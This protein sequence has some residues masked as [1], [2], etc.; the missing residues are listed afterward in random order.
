MK[1]LI[2]FSTLITICLSKDEKLNK[3]ECIDRSNGLYSVN[4]QFKLTIQNDGN[5]VINRINDSAII[6]KVEV[7]EEE[8]FK[9]CM[10]G[11]KIKLNLSSQKLF[12]NH[13]K[14][15]IILKF[16]L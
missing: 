1:I 4:K 2:V 13:V 15:S 7:V 11:L 10:E 14:S 9:A 5:L 3:G 16:F 6:W 12:Y 8:G